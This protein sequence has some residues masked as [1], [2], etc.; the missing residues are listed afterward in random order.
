MTDPFA[1]N[2]SNDKVYEA[3]AR[4]GRVQRVRQT[5]VEMPTEHSLVALNM[6]YPFVSLFLWSRLVTHSAF[7]SQY[8]YAFS[9]AELRAFHRP[10]SLDM[11]LITP[12]RFSRVR[13]VKNLKALKHLK[14]EDAIKTSKDLS[15]REN[16]NFVLFEFSVSFF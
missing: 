14:I 11:P 5:F 12:I 15:I 2:I 10:A 13:N 6:Y 16:V 1:L 8:K 4:E 7:N 9:K 3:F